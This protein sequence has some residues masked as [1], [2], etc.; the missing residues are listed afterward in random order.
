ME[1]D[2]MMRWLKYLGLSLLLVVIGL[3]KGWT[4]MQFALSG[5][6]TTAQFTRFST[7]RT[8]RGRS[9]GMKNVH[10]RFTDKKGA[11]CIG[12]DEVSEDWSEPGGG[13]LAI[14]YLPGKKELGSENTVSRLKES[15][16]AYGVWLFLGG[17]AATA[18]CGVMMVRHMK[19]TPPSG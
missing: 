18:F 13:T 10:Y 19:T 4:D 16:R 15:S 3:W 9:T 1:D 6:E 17:L 12:A 7:S 11:A 14:V 2:A 5:T 8:S